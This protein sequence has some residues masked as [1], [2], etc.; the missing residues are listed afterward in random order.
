M[1]QPLNTSFTCTHSLIDSAPLALQERYAD[2]VSKLLQGRIAAVL[3]ASDRC[4][5]GTQTDLSGPGLKRLLEAQGAQVSNV[6]LSPDDLPVLT[7]HLQTLVSQSVPLILTTGGTG[8]SRRDNTPEATLEICDR[9]VPG[10]A[11]YLRQT[12]LEDTP[13]AALS[14]GVCGIADRSLVINLPGSPSGSAKGL[15]RILHLLPHSL[16]LIAGRTEHTS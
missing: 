12:G 3:T 9:L 1:R 5:A 11:E 15:Q 10:M 8:L 7:Q 16:D 2:E 13:F 14:R 6:I 4:F